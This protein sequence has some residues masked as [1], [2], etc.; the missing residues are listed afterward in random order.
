MTAQ[1]PGRSLA[2]QREG[3]RYDSNGLQSGSDDP[4]A[5]HALLH[6]RLFEFAKPRI[7]VQGPFRDPETRLSLHLLNIS[8]QHTT[9]RDI[10]GIEERYDERNGYKTSRQLRARSRPETDRGLR[11]AARREANSAR[12]N[13][14]HT[15]SQ[16]VV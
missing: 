9:V 12:P 10:S 5:L 14:R 1:W 11:S 16:L 6:Q 3:S 8:G 4:Q 7:V 13:R 15:P 2:R